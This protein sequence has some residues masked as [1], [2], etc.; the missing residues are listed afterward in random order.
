M[1]I[2]STSIYS[3]AQIARHKTLFP[4]NEGQV[5][6]ARCLVAWHLK[7]Q[8][9]SFYAIRQIL[10]CSPDKARKMVAHANHL[11]LSRRQQT[12]A[13]RSVQ[14]GSPCQ[15]GH[16]ARGAAPGCGHPAYSVHGYG[17]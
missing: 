3:A 15:V 4:L 12:A 9:F 2:P 6:E 8:G 17:S 1:A 10:R 5:F 13:S 11:Q 16:L 14:P 7:D